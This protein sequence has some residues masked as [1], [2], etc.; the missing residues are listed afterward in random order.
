MHVGFVTPELRRLDSIKSDALCLCLFQEDWPLRGMPGLV[1]WRVCG[2]LSRQREAGWI[3][4]DEGEMVLMPLAPRLHCEKLLIIGMGSSRTELTDERLTAGLDRMF[5]SLA[6]M[7]AHATVLHL[8]GRPDRVPANKVMELLL[9]VSEQ[10]PDH[11]EV[12][13]VEPVDAQ[14]SMEQVIEVWRGYDED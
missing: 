14:Q 1:D 7:R 13:V 11:A 3:T 4:C 10:H 5:R 12:I 8:P 9:A 2:H 6:R